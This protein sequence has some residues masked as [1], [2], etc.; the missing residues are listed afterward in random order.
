MGVKFGAWNG[1]F[2]NDNVGG[3]A[4]V[5]GLRLS[6]LQGGLGAQPSATKERYGCGLPLAGAMT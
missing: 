3:T 1:N 2:C 6:R 4:R 5:G